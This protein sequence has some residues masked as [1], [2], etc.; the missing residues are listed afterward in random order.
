MKKMDKMNKVLINVSVPSLADSYD[1]FIPRDIRINDVIPY[2]SRAI[3]RFSEGEYQ[4]S[5]REILCEYITG[6]I[7]DI[8]YS[9]DELGIGN[10]SRL[11]LI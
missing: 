3:E 6:K 4:S 8:N 5:S 1:V 11:I 9:A 2:I 7:F 10:G